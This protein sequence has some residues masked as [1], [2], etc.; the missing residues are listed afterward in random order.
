MMVVGISVARVSIGISITG[1]GI[2]MVSTV[3]IAIK[4]RIR[5]GIGSRLSISIS[6]GITLHD[7]NS[8]TRVGV[9]P[10]RIAI[11]IGRGIGREGQVAGIAGQCVGTV[12]CVEQRW[13]SI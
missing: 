7:M 3:G 1:V 10:G 12:G 11:G 4:S 5:I 6:L 13:V 2:R 9:V 8:A